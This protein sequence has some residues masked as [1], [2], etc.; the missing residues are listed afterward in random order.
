MTEDAPPA[1]LPLKKANVYNRL[2][3][4]AVGVQDRQPRMFVS[5]WGIAGQARAHLATSWGRSV[6]PEASRFFLFPS[7]NSFLFYY[8]FFPLLAVAKASWF[9]DADV[10][11]LFLDDCLL[12]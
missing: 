12:Q 6:H 1:L 11:P 8:F 2:G 3:A 9:F 7:S 10:F 4:S 5:I